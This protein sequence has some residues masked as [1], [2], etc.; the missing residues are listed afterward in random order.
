MNCSK[1]VTTKS[2]GVDVIQSAK[3]WLKFEKQEIGSKAAYVNGLIQE[4]KQEKMIDP[5]H[6]RQCYSNAWGAF[7]NVRAAW[8]RLQSFDGPDQIQKIRIALQTSTIDDLQ[9][10]LSD[11]EDY[12][13]SP[14]QEYVNMISTFS[15]F[16]EKISFNRV[17]FIDAVSTLSGFRHQVTDKDRNYGELPD[18]DEIIRLDQS[19]VGLI[20]RLCDIT[21]SKLV[22][23]SR[24]RE[25]WSGGRRQLAE[26]LI[27]TGLRRD[28]W[29]PEWMI[30]A[31]SSRCD[32]SLLS[33]WMS[34]SSVLEA[35]IIAKESP[36]LGAPPVLARR[37]GILVTD[38]FDGFGGR[39]YFQALEYFGCTDAK[40]P[41]Q[42]KPGIRT[43]QD[44]PTLL[45]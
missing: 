41:S 7:K 27:A 17:I 13:R 16:R 43:A 40:M 6:W 21:G 38:E 45:R 1:Y 24:C 11:F 25:T 5:E 33:K 2:E 34:W 12:L 39:D 26:S 37:A 3:A 20:A 32:W 10:S 35:L 14:P 42:S 18:A 36:P 30:P 4:I 44:Y 29:H 8:A 28:L 23:T 31:G 9:E 22:L 19:S 15:L